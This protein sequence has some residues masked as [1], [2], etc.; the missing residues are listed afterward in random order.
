MAKVEHLRYWV[1]K[2]LP[3]VYDDS[4]SYY[5]LLDKVVKKLNET[6]DVANVTEEHIEEEVT[7]ILNEWLE[8]GTLEE[9]ISQYIGDLGDRVTALEGDVDTIE[10]NI[11]GI[12]G[13]IDSIEDTLDGI[14]PLDDT[15]TE[16]STKGV[17]SGGVFDAIKAFKPAELS[18]KKML[19]IGDSYN[20]GNGGI[21][22]RGWGYY[23]A[24][25]TGADCTIIHQNG[26]GFAVKGNEN[27]SYPNKTYAELVSDLN[28]NANYDLIVAQGGWNDASLTKN[29]DGAT[30]VE[31][32]VSG[33]ISA[34][35]LKYPNAEVVCLACYNDTYPLNKQQVRLLAIPRTASKLGV[36]TCFS[37]YLWLQNS[38]YNS[39]DDIHLVDAGY[40]QLA[41]CIIA[42]LRG[43]SGD[44][45]FQKNITPEI[46]KV[47]NEGITLGENFRVYV[48]KEFAWA[49]GDITLNGGE[50][51]NWTPIVTGVPAP[52]YSCID[53]S[54]EWGTE[55]K[56]PLRFIAS[57]DNSMQVR[58]GL[59]GNYR[60]NIIYPINL[61]T[62]E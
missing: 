52:R 29:L 23:V 35:Q 9:I 54:G 11:E 49:S 7:A 51:S 48:N 59:S 46:T 36:K 37:S 41:N 38:G 6:I 14:L 19:L 34:I 55:Y 57:T 47:V 1:Q 20:N 50:I 25:F 26:G 24:S 5:E 22:G 8:D 13:N 62:D 56:R 16:N 21:S 4:L 32:G 44:I 61:E 42:Y 15:P 58:Y 18:S 31:Q 43:W 40:Q 45:T 53:I 30:G 33:F 60:L 3:L 10:G 27:A 17:T 39:S 28:P 2:V 12:D